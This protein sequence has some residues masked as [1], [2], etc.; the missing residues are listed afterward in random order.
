MLRLK[1]YF[2]DSR[3]KKMF[4]FLYWSIDFLFKKKRI[5]K[6]TS[7]FTLKT[8]SV[9][10]LLNGFRVRQTAWRS[11]FSLSWR[12]TEEWREKRTEKEVSGRWHQRRGWTYIWTHWKAVYM[13]W[14]G[15][16][17]AAWPTIHAHKGITTSYRA[18][19]VFSWIPAEKSKRKASYKHVTL[20]NREGV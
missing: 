1:F 12:Q 4:T 15:G 6:D 16:V 5:Y 3:R 8:I 17:S 2:L 18:T 11:L 14:Q 19:S 10:Q 13:H 9:D 7:F 20:R